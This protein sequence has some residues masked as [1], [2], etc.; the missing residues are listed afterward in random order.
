MKNLTER[1]NKF[2][3]T[4]AAISPN[5]DGEEIDGKYTAPD[6]YELL[7]CAELIDKGIKPSKCWS[8]WGSG[9]YKPYSSR[10]GRN[11]HNSLI[12]EIYKIING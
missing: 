1:I 9:A 3:E 4:Y 2:I 10:E 8:D 5:W 6:V 7:A 11:E 12:L